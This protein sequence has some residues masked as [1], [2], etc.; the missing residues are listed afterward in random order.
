MRHLPRRRFRLCVTFFLIKKKQKSD[1]NRDTE[2]PKMAMGANRSSAKGHPALRW[3][4]HFVGIKTREP[5]L[6]RQPLGPCSGLSTVKMRQGPI[7]RPTLFPYCAVYSK[8][9]ACC[10][11]VWS[12][13]PT[14]QAGGSSLVFLLHIPSGT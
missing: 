2:P 11:R 4:L 10:G 12:G 5:R 3:R 1:K 13:W 6:P 7:G 14:V 8:M 9:N